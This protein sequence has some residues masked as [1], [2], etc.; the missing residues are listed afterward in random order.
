[1]PLLSWAKIAVILLSIP[2]TLLLLRNN[3][4]FL[5]QS[6]NFVLSPLNHLRSG[7]IL[8]GMTACSFYTITSAS[9]T[10]ILSI[11][12]VVSSE[13]S[14]SVILNDSNCSDNT[15]ILFS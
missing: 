13:I 15:S 9:A 12:S 6:L 8:F 14:S 11:Y 3:W 2:V 1:M 4:I 5:H 7:T 10:D